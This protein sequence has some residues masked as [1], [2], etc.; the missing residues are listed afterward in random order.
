MSCTTP[1]PFYIPYLSIP[2]FL[3]C[4]PPLPFLYYIPPCPRNYLSAAAGANASVL[5]T[6]ASEI[7]GGARAASAIAKA[8]RL[9][10]AW[11]ELRAWNPSSPF[12][13]VHPPISLLC[14]ASPLP[15][16]SC[17]LRPFFSSAY[18]SVPFSVLH[19][20]VP[21]LCLAPHLPSSI[22]C[23]PPFPFFCSASLRYPFCIVSPLPLVIIC[24]RRRE[25]VLAC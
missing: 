14:H 2:L 23:I 24:Q 18:P 21:F 7:G 16:L 9:R 20:L 15:P 4:I 6:G 10:A 8:R 11:T 25:Q 22:S 17:T 1:S 13:A 5:A 19:P 12:N 3:F